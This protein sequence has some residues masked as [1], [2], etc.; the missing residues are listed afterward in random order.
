MLLGQV[1][2]HVV[3]TAKLDGL[4][5][6]KLLLVEIDTLGAEGLEATGRHLVCVDTVGAGR[7]ER[8]LVVMGNSSRIAPDMEEV[9][10]DA[11]I[12]GIVD[13]LQ[14]ADRVLVPMAD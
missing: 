2:T 3:S 10:S 12:V 7:G 13:S 8:V 11:V 9:P 1:K 14:A 6:K 5:G 4:V